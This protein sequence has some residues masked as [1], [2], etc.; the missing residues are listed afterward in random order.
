[1]ARNTTTLTITVNAK[2]AENVL[3]S[4]KA[5]S[6]ELEQSLEKM[7]QE[8]RD[9]EW[10]DSDED[11][12]KKKD[13][14]RQI[15][16]VKKEAEA[17]AKAYKDG[18]KSVEGI[19]AILQR[20]S[21]ASYNELT[22]TRTRL[23]GRL[24]GLRQ[25]TEDEII[26]YQ[27]VSEKLAKVEEEIAARRVSMQGNMTEDRRATVMGDL[28]LGSYKEIEEAIKITKELQ[29]KQKPGSK[30]WREYGESI[31]HATKYISQYN[32]VQKRFDMSKQLS[33]VSQMSSSDLAAQERYWKAMVEG[34][35]KSAEALRKYRENLELVREEQRKRVETAATEVIGKVEEGKWK[36]T[37]NDTKEAISL[38][39]QY[40]NVLAEAD[41]AG[42]K[43]VDDVLEVLQQKTKE[44]EKGYIS[45]ENALKE[46]KDIRNF[47]GT[48]EDLE[49]IQ[50]ALKEARAQKLEIKTDKSE[51]EIKEIDKAL[52]NVGRRM[53]D[54]KV[55]AKSMQDVLDNLHTAKLEDLEAVAEQLKIEMRGVA[56]GTEDYIEISSQLKRVNAAMDRIKKDTQETE[57]AIVRTGKRL[58]SYVAVYATYNQAASMVRRLL[59]G[60]LALSDSMADIQKTTGM[61]SKEVAELGRSIDSIDT[62]TSQEQLYELAAAAGQL[63]LKGQEDVLG[64]TKAAN[65]ISVALSELGTEGTTELMKIANLTGD[66]QK[67]GTEDALIRIGSA[68]NELTANSAATAGPIG[69]FVSRVG[70]IAAASNVATHEMAAIG[71]TADATGQSMEVA[72][73]TMN[74]VFTALTSNTRGIA[75][76]VNANFK[77]LDEL[78]KGGRTMEAL[79]MV[80]DA[81]RQSGRVTSEAMKEL[82]SDGARM[83][84]F[85]TSLVGNL[86]MLQSNLKISAGAFEEMTSVVNE[87]NVKNESAMGLLQRIG[88]TLDEIV[89]NPRVVQWITD[90]LNSLKST[91]D[92]LVK[93]EAAIQT[94]LIALGSLLGINIVKAVVAWNRSWKEFVIIVKLSTKT[95]GSFVKQLKIVY[96]RV[97]LT[98]GALGKLKTA[99]KG[100]F[101]MIT[102]FPLVGVVAAVGGLVAALVDFN[103]E[104][105]EAAKNTARNTA[106]MTAEFET[107]KK[108]VDDLF[109]SAKAANDGSKERSELISEINKKYGQYL[110]YMLDEKATA[111][112]LAS[113]Q[114]LV[115][116]ELKKRKDLMLIKSRRESADEQYVDQTTEPINRITKQMQEAGLDSKQIGEAIA[117]MNRLTDSGAS[118]EEILEAVEKQT[119]KTFDKWRDGANA[120]VDVWWDDIEPMTAE[121]AKN[122]GGWDPLGGKGKV[123]ELANEALALH[124]LV[125][126]RRVYNDEIEK[127]SAEQAA[128]EKSN[129]Q[130][131]L[132]SQKAVLSDMFEQLRQMKG[133]EGQALQEREAA[134]QRFYNQLSSYIAQ[135]TGKQKEELEKLMAAFKQSVKEIPELAYI[136]DYWGKGDNLEDWTTFR[137]TIKNL[138]KASPTNLADTLKKIEEESAD[139]S[140]AGIAG[141]NKQFGTNFANDLDS[142]NLSVKKLGEQ[143]RNRLSE[144]GRDVNAGFAWDSKRGKKEKKTAQQLYRELLA[145]LEAY[146]NE[147][148]TFIRR[149][150]M[151]EGRL[152][153]EI[154]RDIEN[155]KMQEWNDRIELEKALLDKFYKES[156]FDP[157]KYMGDLTKLPYFAGVNMEEVRQVIQAAG[158]KLEAD[159]VKSMTG[160]MVKVEEKLYQIKQRIEKILLE[161]DFSEQVAQQYLQSLDQLG[162]LFNVKTETEDHSEEEGERRLAI[163]KEWADKAYQMDSDGLKRLV[164]SNELFRQWRIGRTQEDYDAL[165]MMLRKYHDDAEEATKKSYER[166]KKIAE[167]QFQKKDPKTGKSQEDVANERIEGEEADLNMY[168]SARDLGLAS[169][170]RVDDAQIAVLNARIKKEQE[171]MEVFKLRMEMQILAEEQEMT[172]AQN[173]LRMLE[174]QGL[175][176]AEHYADFAAKE[177]AYQDLIAQ[178]DLGTNEAYQR[179]SEYEQQ[180]QDVELSI[181][182]RKLNNLKQYT[183]AVVTFGEQMGEA[184]F[185]EVEDRKEAAKQLLKTTLQLTKDL[186]MAEVKRL[187]MKKALGQQEV[188]QEQVK[189]QQITLTKG[190]HQIANL[191]S[192]MAAAQGENS[193]NTSRAGGKTLAELGWWGIPLIAVISAALSALLGA[194]MGAFSKAKSEVS[195]A[196]GASS[197][198]LATGMLTYAEGNYPVLGNDGNVYNAKYEGSGMKTG[199][200]RGGA[201]FGI[202]SEKKPEAIIDGDTTQ[203]LIMNHPDIWK[204]IVTL[205]KNGR[206]DS[207]MGMRTFATG[208][209]DQLAKQAS[210]A[211]TQA[212]AAQNEA[213]NAMMERME[214]LLAANVN[215]MNKLATEGVQSRINMYGEDG[216]YKNMEKAKKYANRVGYR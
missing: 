177:Q 86:D 6:E 41:P 54:A 77:E 20:V 164:K 37:I 104:M 39:N 120:I 34:G 62:R 213:Q 146:Y 44:A 147:R 95:M 83:N 112:D 5:R 49:N 17:T 50:K 206:L 74:K 129:N 207:G 38:L 116:A 81:M 33:G 64:F 119:G 58:A 151:E 210:Q 180:I 190:E 153:S 215:L 208:N 61:T 14:E 152:E 145:E 68:I 31:A 109:A 178:R 78:V 90:L 209:I 101:G 114:A 13:L 40:R 125:D 199:I 136:V 21:T 35:A 181:T 27:K 162:L 137:D 126:A 105:D 82:G 43:K 99:L 214:A 176:K 10:T 187:I 156:T 149:K 204:A 97:L 89:S 88:N 212:A 202:F 201:H 75:Q 158:P 42:L 29:E 200:Y 159:I 63:G 60:N 186:I 128:T 106:R 48:L 138:D 171:L 169:Q 92:W 192:D 165:L 166:Q 168:E 25:D 103:D 79:V 148:E 117:L 98:S 72:G 71:A 163:M 4:L 87:Y 53:T 70:G 28:T 193:I 183:D 91:V 57:N 111:E 113:A 143:I 56:Q 100:I 7:N 2:Q 30:M 173:T 8:L 203:R 84:Q 108:A 135:S 133:T 107:E 182:E 130:S 59:D 51:K 47:E 160:S 67:Y 52:I 124:D 94:L 9:T 69:D 18:A 11:K 12:K 15:A 121:M 36:G 205:S 170:R 139:I 24:R 191:S 23:Q 211:E 3:Q 131:V 134:Y 19:D 127:L 141:F 161:D 198:R 80:L 96:S 115:N 195:A 16:S 179:I 32:D 1:M 55:S 22:R 150:G 93:S 132:D 184:A 46:A 197:G 122:L 65:M 174:E 118:Y 73:T 157:T 140:E 110:G 185:G 188:V 167:Q 76:A 155:L 194:A 216:L 189:E 66:I 144:L 102:R 196:T 175:A 123:K 172:I 85:I 142:F 26:E 45:F 154:N